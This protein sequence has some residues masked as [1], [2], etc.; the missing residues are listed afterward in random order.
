MPKNTQTQR[1]EQSI[2]QQFAIIVL[3]ID[4]CRRLEMALFK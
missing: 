1:V 4:L 3:S 2:T